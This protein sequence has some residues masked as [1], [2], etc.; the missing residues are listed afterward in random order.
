MGLGSA[1]ASKRFSGMKPL[2]E[3]K[4]SKVKVP[5]FIQC[6]LYST[7]VPHTQG[8]QSSI[9]QFYKIHYQYWHLSF[10]LCSTYFNKYLQLHQLTIKLNILIIYQLI[11]YLITCEKILTTN[12]ILIIITKS[13]STKVLDKCVS[14]THISPY[15]KLIPG[16]VVHGP[17][18]GTK[19]ICNQC[20]Y[21]GNF[22]RWSAHDSLRYCLQMTE[23]RKK[24]KLYQLF[25]G[26]PC[27]SLRKDTPV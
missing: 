19:H 26:P 7:G 8:N 9:T 16:G 14:K 27:I 23:L 2:R 24:Q 25:F 18:N 10:R 4:S 13:N 22:W 1:G 6:S 11:N 17:L 3:L 21:T 15:A 12:N 20:F 5:V